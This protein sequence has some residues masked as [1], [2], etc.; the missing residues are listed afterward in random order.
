MT[1][2]KVILVDSAD[3]PVGEM[4]KMEAHRKALLHRAFSVFV[5]NSEGQLMLQRRAGH[6]Y[7]SGGL[8]TNTVCSHPRPGEATS[9][10]ALRR[11]KE[12]MGFTTEL[13]KIFHFIY[14]AELDGGL[15]EHE[16]D[17]VFVGRYDGTPVLNPDE[18]DAYEFKYLSEIKED[19]NRHPERYTEWFKIIFD[20]SLDVLLREAGK[21]F[22]DRPLV[23]KPYFEEKIWGGN[24]L[25]TFFDKNI[26]SDHTGESWEVSAVEGKESVVR[27]GFFKGFDLRYLWKILGSEF[28]GKL[29]IRKDFPLLVKYIDARDDLSVQVHPDDKLA[30]RKHGSYGKNETWM[31]LDAEEESHLYIGFKPGIKQ[32][33]YLQALQENKVERLL[34]RI[35]VKPGDWYF[36]PAGTVHAIGKGVLLI[37]I[38]QSSDVTY[39]IYDY[40]RKDASGQARPLHIEAALEAIRF[41]HTP[42]RVTGTLLDTPYFKVKRLACSRLKHFIPDTFVIV[43]NPFE[44]ELHINRTRLKKGETMMIFASQP[45]SV[46]DSSDKICL[47]IFPR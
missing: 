15:T 9:V 13:R 34:N 40:N 22:I 43:S 36:I 38:Q 25:K 29:D 1:E 5:F 37:E 10:A 17:H 35:P 11:L 2:E 7:H 33:D 26:P 30:L 45:L 6:K 44:E 31:I 42:L 47:L 24:R 16:L 28:W 4:D 14:K 23:W 21:M 32:A 41:D 12:E 20:K 8:W 39:R 3:R 18:T 46:T 27:D 19:I